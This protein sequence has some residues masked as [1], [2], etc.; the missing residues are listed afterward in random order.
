MTISHILFI[1]AVLER[2]LKVYKI[3]SKLIRVV[4]QTLKTFLI[5]SK[6]CSHTEVRNVDLKKSFSYTSLLW[7]LI[8]V[9]IEYFIA[10]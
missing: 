5:C 7:H 8:N 6:S 9:F 4:L 2:S 1:S 3:C 10:M